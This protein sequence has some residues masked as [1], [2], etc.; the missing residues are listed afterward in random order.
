M[1]RIYTITFLVPLMVTLLKTVL[2]HKELKNGADWFE[3]PGSVN[4]NSGMYEI[5]MLENAKK[6]YNTLKY[7]FYFQ[8][9]EKQIQI[10]F[11]ALSTGNIQV[12]GFLKDK[13]YLYTL[14]FSFE[15]SPS[16]LLDMIKECENVCD[17]INYM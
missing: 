17:D 15:M 9:I 5:G 7:T 4:G 1:Q 6:L 11:E 10:K 12:V 8:P 2:G 3:M 14:N 16:E 13:S